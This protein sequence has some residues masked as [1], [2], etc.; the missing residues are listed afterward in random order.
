[1]QSMRGGQVPAVNPIQNIQ[2]TLSPIRSLGTFNQGPTLSP[3][4]PLMSPTFPMHQ[5]NPI[6]SRQPHYQPSQFPSQ[7]QL[8]LMNQPLRTYNTM[9]DLNMHQ[10]ARN[11]TVPNTRATLP[12]VKDQ[13]KSSSFELGEKSVKDD[14]MCKIC[15]DKE[16]T[17]VNTKCFHM[18]SCSVCVTSLKSSCPI[19]RATGDF[20]KVYK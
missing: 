19:C 12:V 4:V 8:M 16:A 17:H 20:R 13:A 11:S 9:P 15:L 5:N 6:M 1:M 2:F 7:N 18:S 10:Q 14:A 3:T